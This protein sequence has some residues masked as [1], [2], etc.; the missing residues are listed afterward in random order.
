VRFAP[1]PAQT[2][3]CPDLMSVPGHYSVSKQKEFSTPD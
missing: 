2:S 1:L 3:V